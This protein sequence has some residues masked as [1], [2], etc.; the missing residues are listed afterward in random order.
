[1]DCIQ[2]HHECKTEQNALRRLPTRLVFVGSGGLPVRVCQSEPLPSDT[3]YM[4]LSHCWGQ[5]RFL[6]LTTKNIIALQRNIAFAHL[7]ATFQDAIKFARYVGVDYLWIDSLCIIQDSKDDWEKESILMESVYSN[8]F[9]NIA[10]AGASDGSGGCFFNRSSDAHTRLTIN[11]ENIPR[12]QNSWSHVRAWITGKSLKPAENE[13]YCVKPGEYWFHED[14]FWSREVISSDLCS[15]AWVIQ[16][17]LLAKR[18][19]YFCPTQIL[20]ECNRLRA[21]ETWQPESLPRNDSDEIRA[22]LVS[23]NLN[24]TRRDPKPALEAWVY[25]VYNYSGCELTYEKD[26]LI[27]LAGLAR[28]FQRFLK[29]QYL[30]GLWETGFVHQL[31]WEN[32]NNST[33]PT[34]YQAPSW[35][36]A[37]NSGGVSYRPETYSNLRS[38]EVTVDILDVGVGTVGGSEFSQVTSGYIKMIGYLIPVSLQHRSTDPD[39]HEYTGGPYLLE[40]YTSTFMPDIR[41]SFESFPGV[42]YCAPLVY[43][44]PGSG[45]RYRDLEKSTDGLVLKPTGIMK[46]QYQR[47]GYFRGDDYQEE[48]SKMTEDLYEAYDEVTDKYTFTI[49]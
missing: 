13:P 35:S 27:A 22:I 46:G 40:P 38:G 7:P 3:R 8:G 29:S 15:R 37:S 28:H 39:F 10:A 20:F 26:R 30:A 23:A 21:C 17:R 16:E 47:V 44:T 19:L 24:F 49:I 42:F 14:N 43:T 18:V 36:W 34:S 33:R 6:T 48:R 2:N 4:T 12:N 25:L 32:R 41:D 11:T 31:C 45:Y 9:C 5:V 1:L